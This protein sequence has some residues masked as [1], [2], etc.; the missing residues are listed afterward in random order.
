MRQADMSE[1]AVSEFAR[2]GIQAGR[3]EV[4]GW[5]K[6]KDGGAS[7]GGPVH[8]AD[9]DFIERTFADAEHERPLLLEADIGSPLDQLRGDSVGDAG[10]SA[11]AAG[12]EH[13]SVG[14]IRTAGDI[15]ADIRVGLL[16]N[17][18]RRLFGTAAKDLFDEI[19]AAAQSEFFGHDAQRT[20]RGDEIHRL[21]PLV[22][23]D[24]LQKMA[25]E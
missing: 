8:V 6:W 15:C 23:V 21:D 25:K 18:A 20:V 11:H 9:V 19:A 7:V 2:D 12:D 13:H 17:F 3:T 1:Y 10:Q 16:M 22:A 4:E 14:G 24:G 5:D